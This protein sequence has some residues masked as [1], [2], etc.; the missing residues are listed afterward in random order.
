MNY[1]TAENKDKSQAA[2]TESHSV[3][4][5]FSYLVIEQRIKAE[6]DTD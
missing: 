2:T 5:A 6:G 3:I 4:P 1:I